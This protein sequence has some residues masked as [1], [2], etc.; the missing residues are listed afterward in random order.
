MGFV[1]NKNKNLIKKCADVL[2][3]KTLGIALQEERASLL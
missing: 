1:K 3:K 2:V